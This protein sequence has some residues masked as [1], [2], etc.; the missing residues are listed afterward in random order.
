MKDEYAETGAESEQRLYALVR[1]LLAA[2]NPNFLQALPAF[3]LR[4]IEQPLI[5]D[6]RLAQV[7]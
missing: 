4:K 2:I 6:A 7:K 3:S 5:C 1:D